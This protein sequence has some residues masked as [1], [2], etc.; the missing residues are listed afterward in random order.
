MSQ[1]QGHLLSCQVT[2]KKY[3][4]CHLFLTRG[5]EEATVALEW[6]RGNKQVRFAFKGWVF[7]YLSLPLLIAAIICTVQKKSLSL[8]LSL[9]K[10]LRW[11]RRLPSWPRPGLSQ[12]IC[13]TL[14]DTQFHKLTRSDKVF[15]P[16]HPPD[17]NHHHCP[18]IDLNK[19]I[20]QNQ[21]YDHYFSKGEAV[22]WSN[23]N[24]SPD[25]P[26]E[27]GGRRQTF[28]PCPH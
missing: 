6:L 26:H 8:T 14:T 20:H 27:A 5:T 12:K 10:Y 9:K 16:N 22:K 11:Q 25:Q 3:T 19:F 13:S 1:W 4:W 28:L 17:L 7:S 24:P 18:C 15:C 23:A 21:H 2:A